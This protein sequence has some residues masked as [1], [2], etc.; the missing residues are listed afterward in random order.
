MS[1]CNIAIEY[2]TSFLPANSW[3][4]INKIFIRIYRK[5]KRVKKSLSLNLSIPLSTSQPLSL[6][7][8]IPLLTSRP[9][10][11]STALS[12]PPLTWPLSLNLSWP[13]L[14]P[15][16]TSLLTSLNPNLSRPLSPPLSQPQY[17]H[18]SSRALVIGRPNCICLSVCLYVCQD[19]SFL[20][21]RV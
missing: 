21:N 8:L 12:T 16:S 9:L 3:V 11:L 19:L 14:I 15:L 6:D 17:R 7:L 20:K 13:P 4:T 10:N 2:S 5:Q 18:Q 1:L